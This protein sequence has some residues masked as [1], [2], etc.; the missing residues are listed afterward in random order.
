[1][2]HAATAARAGAHFSPGCCRQLNFYFLC[3]RSQGVNRSL[4]GILPTGQQATCNSS[5]PP[6]SLRHKANRQT[7]I[8]PCTQGSSASTP[9]L[10]DACQAG[11]PGNL[12]AAAWRGRSHPPALIESD[13][14]GRPGTAPL[15]TEL[16][17]QRSAWRGVGAL[18][19]SALLPSRRPPFRRYNTTLKP[20]DSLRR[21]FLFQHLPLRM[22]KRWFRYFEYSRARQAGS[23]WHTWPRLAT[24]LRV[25]TTE[26]PRLQR[27]NMRPRAGCGI[28]P[29][30]Q[31]FL[32]P[33]EMAEVALPPSCLASL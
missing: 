18:C 11:N 22:R 8:A 9:L 29:P 3:T 7:C 16:A 2:G 13:T 31:A 25:P 14:P 10:A 15:L 20:W 1:M 4:S 27:F 30:R 17:T 24:W 19:L 26:V 33:S 6:S 21:P 28:S 5:P 23:R 32:W 12:A